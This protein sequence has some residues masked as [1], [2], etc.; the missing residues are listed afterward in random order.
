MHEQVNEKV[1]VITVFSSTKRVTKPHAVKW[2]G[3]THV[4]TDIGYHHTVREGRTLKHIFSVSTNTL[5][6]RLTFDT[7]TLGWTL[8]E[9]SD[10]T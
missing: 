4:V 5:A 10:G 3:L 9:V 1:D 6:L 7:E 2:R 8:N